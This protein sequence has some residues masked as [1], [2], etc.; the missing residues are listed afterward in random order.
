MRTVWVTVFRLR[1]GAFSHLLFY[2]YIAYQKSEDFK[3]INDI[4][5]DEINDMSDYEN[6]E[7][8]SDA[9]IK[10]KKDPLWLWYG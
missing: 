1:V 6:A 4:Y 8:L 3:D 5:S 9:D 7:D 10:A 2:Y